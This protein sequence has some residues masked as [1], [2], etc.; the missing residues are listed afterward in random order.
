[1]SQSGNTT[2]NAIRI[3][4]IF[5][6]LKS[7]KLLDRPDKTRYRL[8]SKFGLTARLALL[9]ILGAALL[10]GVIHGVAALGEL[11]PAL[12]LILCLLQ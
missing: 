12:L 9:L 2:I 1:M 10:P 11:C 6:N 3:V 8:I 5:T 7:E 4:N